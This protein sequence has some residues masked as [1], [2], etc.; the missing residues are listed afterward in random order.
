MHRSRVAALVIDCDNMEAGTAFWSQALGA[1]P[2][3]LDETYVTLGPAVGGLVVLLQRVPEPKTV[4]SRMHIDFETDD[5]EAEM[6]RLE[7]LGA[8]RIRQ[9]DAWWVMEDP[10]GNEFCVGGAH[11]PVFEEQART[12]S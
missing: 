3:K 12:W 9:G 8:N 2:R 4:K 1:E 11:T 5:M 10:C 6:Q 7:A